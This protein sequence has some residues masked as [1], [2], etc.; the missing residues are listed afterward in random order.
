MSLHKLLVATDFSLCS[1]IA[2]K[3]A[4]EIA[5]ATGAAILLAHVWD[6]AGHDHPELSPEG[7]GHLIANVVRDARAARRDE[8]ITRAAKL[9]SRGARVQYLLLDGNAD[10]QICHAALHEAADM[11][12]AGT[13]GRHFFQRVLLGS[14]SE[15]VLRAAHVPVLIARSST[16]CEYHRILV[17]T[18]F[19]PHAEHALYFAMQLAPKGGTV[20]LVHFW[21]HPLHHLADIPADTNR[22]DFEADAA[23]RAAKLIAEHARTGVELRF[24]SGQDRPARGIIHRLERGEHDLVCVGSHGRRGTRRLVLGSVAEAVVRHAPCSTLVCHAPIPG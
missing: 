14:V 13:H 11:I 3:Q 10:E 6:T 24:A 15:R 12:V 19:S 7:S 17:A 21:S 1:D 9:R 20:D 5:R 18:D 4:L 23:A 22:S 16:H 8:L 2:T